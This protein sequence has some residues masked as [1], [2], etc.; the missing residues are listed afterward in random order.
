MISDLIWEIIISSFNE[1]TP[2]LLAKVDETIKLYSNKIKNKSVSSEYFKYLKDK[3]NK[4]FW[5][6]NVI[7]KKK[8]FVKLKQKSR[9]KY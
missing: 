3:K 1:F 6:M 7:K 9:R 5:E 2:E 8:P 4:F